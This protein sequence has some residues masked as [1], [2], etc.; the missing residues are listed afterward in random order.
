VIDF[1][2]RLT[3]TIRTFYEVIGNLDIEAGSQ[4]L[5]P[6]LNA[7]DENSKFSGDQRYTREIKQIINDN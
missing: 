2:G 3:K 6:A 4:Q 1:S 5:S 7:F